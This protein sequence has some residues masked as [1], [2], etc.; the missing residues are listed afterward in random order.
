VQVTEIELDASSAARSTPVEPKLRFAALTEQVVVLV[1]VTVNGAEV[2]L[3]PP[4]VVH[5][6]TVE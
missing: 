3:A 2:A 1:A 4:I 5:D 6:P